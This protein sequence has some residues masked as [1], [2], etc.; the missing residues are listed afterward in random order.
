MQ[1]TLTGF[2]QIYPYLGAD[3]LGVPAVAVGYALAAG[4]R[5][6]MAISGL[7]MVPSS[8]LA[9][10][11]EGEYWSPNRLGG[12]VVGVEDVICCFS[13]GSLVWLAA[14]WPFRQ[15]LHLDLR[16]GRFCRRCLT[17][18]VLGGVV[19]LVLW[20]A[21]LGAMTSA[22]TIQVFLIVLLLA[23]RSEL[24]PIS[25]CAAVGYAP[26]YL[27]I[28]YIASQL[29]PGFTSMWGGYK[30]WGPRI[31]GLPVDEAVWVA[32]FAASWSLIIAYASDARLVKPSSRR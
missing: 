28:L 27:A 20:M 15:R 7:L 18:F 4:Q 25:L 2:F 21:G 6:M 23:M 29:F 30:L 10:I 12:W 8:W 22:V 24:W 32:T 9:V 13:L 14:V 5:R 31:L 1:E 19:L 26:Y 17:V 3:L 11:H 16:A